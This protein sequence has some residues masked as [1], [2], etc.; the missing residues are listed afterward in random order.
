MAALNLGLLNGL[1][2]TRLPLG[3]SIQKS[4]RLL[5]PYYIANTNAD[6]EIISREAV[7]S[8]PLAAAGLLMGGLIGVL[9]GHVIGATIGYYR[10]EVLGIQPSKGF[11]FQE[12]LLKR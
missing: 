9:A 8:F 11:F 4:D 5:F 10:N 3:Y 6:R 1:V 12:H 7:F 2:G